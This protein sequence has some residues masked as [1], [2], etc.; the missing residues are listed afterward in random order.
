MKVSHTLNNYLARHYLRNLLVM[1]GALLAVI[2]LFDVVELLRRAAKYD[3]ITLGMVLQMG[4]L[5]LPEAGQIVLPFAIL[6]SAIFTFWQL[7]RRH[8]LVVVRAAG[9]SVWQF[10]APILAVG[11]GFGALQMAVINPAG[12][13][14]LGKFERMENE[15]L[16]RK[17]SYVALFREGLWLRQ[18]QEGGTVILHANRVDTANWLL[19]DVMALY[20]THDDSFVQRL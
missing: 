16:A 14:L 3:D 17:T 9:F 11:I 12:S 1:L 8:E 20:F 2:Y 7:T 19:H 15:Y 6:F 4:L 10:L 5:K 18:Q 13:L